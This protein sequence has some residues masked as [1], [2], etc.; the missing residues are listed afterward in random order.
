MEEEMIQSAQA[1]LQDF[2]DEMKEYEIKCE[3]LENENE[4][5][6]ETDFFEE[7]CQ[8]QLNDVIRIQD[9][10]LSKKALSLEQS[11]RIALNFQPP[12]SM[13]KSL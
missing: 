7:F 12:L 8:I 6:Y 10:Y 2:M 3:K 1:V 5:Y 9:K 11:R 13:I 4:N